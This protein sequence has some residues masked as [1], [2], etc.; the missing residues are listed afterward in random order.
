MTFPSFFLSMIRIAAANMVKG[1]QKSPFVDIIS[2]GEVLNSLRGEHV[3]KKR[4]SNR[5]T[6]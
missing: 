4:K 5:R 1:L 6:N 3:R 2:V